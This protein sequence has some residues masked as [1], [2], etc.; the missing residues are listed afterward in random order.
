MRDNIG[1]LRY[2]FAVLLEAASISDYGGRAKPISSLMAL[3]ILK[4]EVL[5]H[6]ENPVREHET[7]LCR[8]LCLYITSG[9]ASE[10]ETESC[11]C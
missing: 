6:G 10:R 1:E 7:P 9:P 3:Q 8:T 11:I 2:L 5:S 4:T